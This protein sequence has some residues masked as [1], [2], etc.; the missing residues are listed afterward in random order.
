MNGAWLTLAHV[1]GPGIVH[2]ADMVTASLVALAVAGAAVA[3]TA[4][5]RR[6]DHGRSS[7]AKTSRDLQASRSP[8]ARRAASQCLRPGG[9]NRPGQKS[10][11]LGPP[12][13]SG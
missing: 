9:R 10:G 6:G 11:R 12:V 5:P 3:W 1:L 8:R 13:G 2:W 7:E 4:S